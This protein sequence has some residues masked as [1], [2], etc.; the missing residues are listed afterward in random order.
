MPVFKKGIYHR[1]YIFFRF[2]KL[3]VLMFFVKGFVFLLILLS[4]LIT[5]QM[6]VVLRTIVLSILLM[7]FG[8]LL[9]CQM[10]YDNAPAS[11]FLSDIPS[12]V[13]QI[14]AAG[15]VSTGLDEMGGVFT[16]DFKEFYFTVRHSAAYAVILSIRYEDGFWRYP[17]VVPFSGL[18]LDADPFITADGRR[19][20]FSSTRPVNHDGQASD[21]NIWLVDLVDGIW[22]EPMFY[23]HNTNRNERFPTVSSEG[24]LFYSVDDNSTLVTYDFMATN[25]WMA[26]PNSDG[27]QMPQV[28]PGSV[29]S[30]WADYTPLISMDGQFL[31]FASNRAGGR[32]ASDLYYCTRLPDGTWEAAVNAGPDVNSSESEHYPSFTPDGKFFLFASDRKLSLSVNH[33][34]LTYSMLKRLGL[35]P[36]NGFNDIYVRKSL[37]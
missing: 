36:G 32:G 37:R 4:F 26:Q 29:N 19:M 12:A 28:L 34:P 31:V 35:G 5:N 15:L 8:F 33:E 22:Q 1:K 20:F 21:W 14:F 6:H 2:R 24:E 7:G 16:P 3:G 11:F 23:S 17:E 9:R 10:R 13:N 18:Y 27:W 25:I 30:E